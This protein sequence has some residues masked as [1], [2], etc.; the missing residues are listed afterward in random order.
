M[1]KGDEPAFKG[2]V[3][4]LLRQVDSACGVAHRRA[5][6]HSLLPGDV[7]HG[8]A[9]D[10]TFA[11]HRFLNNLLHIFGSDAPVPEI[12]WPDGDHHALA[13]VLETAGADHHDPVPQAVASDTILERAVNFQ[14][15]AMAAAGLRCT[16]RAVIGADKNLYLWFW[17]A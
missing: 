13:T 1:L 6:T 10:L 15:P 11:D 9:I 16:F 2:T 8:E 7:R 3:F 4:F 14:G 17:H 5:G 12:S